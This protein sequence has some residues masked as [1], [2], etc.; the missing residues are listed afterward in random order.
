M[1]LR[2]NISGVEIARELFKPSEDSA[3]LGLQWIKILGFQVFLWV[4][5]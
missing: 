4:T 2:G 1:S 3:A 5:S